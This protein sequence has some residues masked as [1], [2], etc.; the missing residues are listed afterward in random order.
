MSEVHDD[1]D[2][3]FVVEQTNAAAAEIARRAADPGM[4]RE[5]RMVPPGWE[6]PKG[7]DGRH[8]PLFYGGGGEFERRVKD[9]AER[10]ARWDSGEDG[11][12]ARFPALSFA[13]WDG[14]PPEH[15]DYMLVGVPEEA[16]TLYQ[17]Y[18]STSEGTPEGPPFATLEE[19]AAHAAEHATT[20]ADFR[21]TKEEWLRMLSP[22]GLVAH[23]EGNVT[24]I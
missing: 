17:L 18:E 22:G 24:F 21:A 4:G 15:D 1:D 19:V 3:E 6:H 20:F 23:T 7:P 2:R 12:R 13:D 14:E 16:C 8:L 5:I 10:K 9:Y 11:N